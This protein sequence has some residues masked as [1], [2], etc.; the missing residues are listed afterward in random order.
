MQ[1]LASI[2]IAIS[3]LL[4]PLTGDHNSNNNNVAR[5]DQTNNSYGTGPA[6]TSIDG[7]AKDAMT[8]RDTDNS[9]CPY[10]YPNINSKDYCECVVGR[11]DNFICNYDCSC[12][13][14]GVLCVS[15]S[16][17]LSTGAILVIVAVVVVGVGACSACV[18]LCVR[19]ARRRRTYAVVGGGHATVHHHHQP[20]V[21]QYAQQPQPQSYMYQH[22]KYTLFISS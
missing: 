5:Q 3:L 4:S 11:S 18:G 15:S 2:F 9:D 22:D 10:K 14:G 20:A 1:G 19:A 6:V 13:F 16:C 17:T 12:S 7:G 21:P 8:I